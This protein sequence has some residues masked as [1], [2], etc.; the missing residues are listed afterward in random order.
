MYIYQRYIIYIYNIQYMHISKVYHYSGAFYVQFGYFKD[1]VGCTVSHFPQVRKL[2]SGSQRGE[3]GDPTTNVA[4]INIRVFLLGGEE[5][6][7]SNK[8]SEKKHW[9]LRSNCLYSTRIKSSLE[10]YI[11]YTWIRWV[12]PPRMSLWGR[13][14]WLYPSI[15]TE[16]VVVILSLLVSYKVSNRD[17]HVGSLL[18]AHPSRIWLYIWY[19]NHP[20]LGINHV[21]QS[22]G[23]P[24]RSV[25]A[26]WQRDGKAWQSQSREVFLVWGLDSTS[27][28]CARRWNRGTTICCKYCLPLLREFDPLGLANMF[29]LFGFTT[30]LLLTML[31]RLVSQAFQDGMTYLWLQ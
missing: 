17:S 22:P 27:S 11:N 21:D 26:V 3:V 14:N 8:L 24:A 25:G 1:F 10:I 31:S 28:K 5:N 6:W 29:Q 12:E 15:L 18:L 16:F 20:S 7:N 2:P 13:L 30:G 4:L 19:C 23:V 9:P